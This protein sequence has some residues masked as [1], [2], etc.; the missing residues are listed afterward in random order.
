MAHPNRFLSF[1]MIAAAAVTLAAGLAALSAPARAVELGAA[2]R[3]A[4]DVCRVDLRAGDGTALWPEV[5]LV[6][7]SS[8]DVGLA[9]GTG[10]TV[11]CGSAGTRPSAPAAGLPVPGDPSIKGDFGAL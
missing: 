4:G 8:I 5:A 9:A 3:V 6:A 10:L 1:L 11:A 7:M 2:A